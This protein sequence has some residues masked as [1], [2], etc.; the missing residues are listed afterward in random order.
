MFSPEDIIQKID[1]D[2]N[3]GKIKLNHSH[4]F[5]FRVNYLLNC[6]TLIWTG[7]PKVKEKG[8][9]TMTFSFK[10]ATNL[11]YVQINP[12]AELEKRLCFVDQIIHTL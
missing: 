3:D 10:S 12:Q 9:K 7:F 1:I 11:S 8:V 2:L 5:L 4:V 6:F